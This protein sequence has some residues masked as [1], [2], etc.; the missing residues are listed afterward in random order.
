MFVCFFTKDT[1][2]Q[3]AKHDLAVSE[4]LPSQGF[5]PFIGGGWL[6]NLVLL[7]MLPPGI[8]QVCEHC[9]H[10]VQS[11][12]SPSRGPANSRFK[13]E[14]FRLLLLAQIIGISLKTG[15]VIFM[16]TANTTWRKKV[17]ASNYLNL[18]CH[19]VFETVTLTLGRTRGVGDCHPPPSEIF[20]SCLLDDKPTPDIFRSSLFIPCAHFETSLVM[21]SFCRYKIWRHK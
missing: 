8:P 5:P 7:R 1:P 15:R 3:G 13:V 17:Y 21:I 11:P 10:G 14:Y 9:V 12:H 16:L 4:S 20:L 6:H 19:L 18:R 2:G